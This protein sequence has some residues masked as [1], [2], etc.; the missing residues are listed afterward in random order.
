MLSLFG[1]ASFHVILNSNS[2]NGSLLLGKF[3]FKIK[4]LNKGDYG[5]AIDS[6]TLEK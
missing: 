6:I 3:T 5:A 2:S 4:I 1:Y